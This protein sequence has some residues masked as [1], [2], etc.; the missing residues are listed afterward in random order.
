MKQE[1][2]KSFLLLFLIFF[3]I[4]IAFNH[5]PPV[6]SLFE[7]VIVYNSFLPSKNPLF[8]LSISEDPSTTGPFNTF[9]YAFLIISRYIADIFGHSISNIRLPSIIFG[10]ISLWLFY[11]IINRFFDWKIAL[12]TTFILATNQYFIFYQHFLLVQMVS[13]ASIL[14]CI[15]RFQNLISKETKL[16]IISFALACALAT[17]HYWT[18]RFV[19]ICLMLFYLINFDEL[20]I[21]KIKTYLKITSYKKIKTILLIFMCMTFILILFYPG[22][23]FLLF[24]P[25]FLYPSFRKE[26]FSHTGDFLY[27]DTNYFLTIWNNII[28]YFKYYIFDRTNS[29][30]DM[31]VNEVPYQVDFLIIILLS[32]IGI[33]FSL[34]K[35]INYSTLFFLYILFVTFFPML[36]S[37]NVNPEDLK[38][39]FEEN[40][41]FANANEASSILTPVRVFYSIP[42]ICLMSVIGGKYIYKFFEDKNLAVKK[43]LIIVLFLFFSFRIYGYF[44]EIKIF[45]EKIESYK[46]DFSKPAK[47]EGLM[48]PKYPDFKEKKEKH[49]NQIYFYKLA[50]FISNEIKKNPNNNSFK[51]ILYIPAKLYTP[52]HYYHGDMGPN[53]GSKYYFPMYLTFYLQEQGINVSYLVKNDDVKEHFLKK[54]VSIVDRYK[55]NKDFYS[56]K[57]SPRKLTL[58]ERQKLDDHLYPKNKEQ[59]RIVQLFSMI[60]DWLENFKFTDRWLNSIR[61]SKGFET[62]LVIGDYHINKTSNKNPDYVIITNSEEFNLVNDK[63]NF[64]VVLSL[65]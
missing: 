45:N 48:L 9:G 46:F 35:N 64:K 12:I 4:F 38:V 33:L 51:K 6:I 23:I 47:S 26:I 11:I 31:V 56:I 65:K 53:K 27:G 39:Y 19:V 28:Y 36:L 54:A 57:T 15:E 43:Y 17:L 8:I 42:F 40:E 13:M 44:H 60:F 5:Y 18:G 10:L 1:K 49:Y 58:E 2:Y 14:F 24:T 63:S 29:S 20:N 34:K 52:Y 7:G 62:D 59:E 50:E 30:V 3:S 37:T 41:R 55:K 16:S 22:N 21:L 61:D 25:E 32:F